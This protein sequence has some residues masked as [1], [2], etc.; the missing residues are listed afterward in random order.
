MKFS[1][2]SCLFPLLTT[3]AARNPDQDLKNV[4]IRS[5]TFQ[6]NGCP[7]GSISTTI[8]PDKTMI[9]LGY[10]QFKLAIGPGFNPTDKVKNCVVQISIN[11]DPVNHDGPAPSFA[12]VGATYH[13]YS[14]LGTGLNKI[15]SST[16]N[17]HDSRMETVEA[18]TEVTIPGPYSVGGGHVF[19]ESK[20]IPERGQLRSPCGIS[21]VQLSVNTRVNLT[22]KFA[23]TYYNEYEEDILPLTHQIRLKWFSC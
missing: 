10:D 5:V 13:G 22:S 17:F 2:I 11:L 15:I 16:Y 14:N 6:G 8:S 7:Q 9:T 23:S 3:C 20:E 19:T 21:P 12:V 1:V 18:R 4:T